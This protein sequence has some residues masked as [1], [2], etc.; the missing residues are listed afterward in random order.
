RCGTGLEG[1]GRRG[2]V[3]DGVPDRRD[4]PRGAD[5][6]EGEDGEGPGEDAGGDRGQIEEVGAA[7]VRG[8]LA[9]GVDAEVAAVPRDRQGEGPRVEAG[10]RA[11]A[12][13]RPD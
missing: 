9:G 6:A 8:D 7:P 2:E 4:R 13:E 11:V 12:E 3:A 10:L 5:V 1:P